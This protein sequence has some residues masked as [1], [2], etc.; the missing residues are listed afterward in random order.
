MNKNFNVILLHEK[1]FDVIVVGAG[2]SGSSTAFFCAREGLNV[3][4][5]DKEFFPRDK[6]CGD[7]ISGKSIKLLNE[8][9][10][11]PKT[12]SGLEFSF[13]K[14]TTLI[15]PKG[16]E[17]KIGFNKPEGEF[18][19]ITCP[20]KQ[21]DSLVFNNAK[22]EESVTVIEGFNVTDVLMNKNQVIG[23]KGLVNGIE[24]EFKAK[25]VVAA[26]GAYSIIRRKL[27][28]FDSDSDNWIVAVR[29][30][31]DNVII[32]DKESI[33]LH[34]IDSILPG[35]FW[36]FPI[37]ETKANVGLG[38]VQSFVPKK[39]LNLVNELN[40]IIKEHPVL[41]KR[42]KDSIKLNEVKAW[43]LPIGSKHRKNYANGVLF[44]GDAAGLIDPFTGEGI[45][46]ALFS[47]KI[48]SI[49]V[50]NAFALNDF[51]EATLKE[52]DE[53][54][55]NELSEE[56]SKSTKLMHL[57]KHRFLLN[58]ALGKAARNPEIRGYLTQ[59]ISDSS[60]KKVGS[61]QFLLKVLLG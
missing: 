24:K 5:L 26:D 6:T 13:I 29:T 15:S 49:A 51:S 18:A 19:G 44:V 57:A 21:F 37:S 42:F 38:I 16:D 46:N 53:L 17:V 34:F 39:K 41:S 60:A 14:S 3:L 8:L 55:W 43:N 33:E 47:G 31:Y 61:M 10:I 48:A 52:F 59:T 1:E 32:P 28:L 27:N 40:K 58:W 56:L 35:Y 54:L 4:L 36:I 45:G 9:G 25:I 20:R 7:G 12:V 2:P 23:V 30:Y 11:N 50:K 22:K